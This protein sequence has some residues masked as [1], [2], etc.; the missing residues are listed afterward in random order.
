MEN[1]KGINIEQLD[2]L[3]TE[4]VAVRLQE[5]EISPMDLAQC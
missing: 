1:K 3:K 4:E 5:M 2:A